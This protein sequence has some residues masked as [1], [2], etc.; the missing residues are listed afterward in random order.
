MVTYV[1]QRLLQS[2]FVLVLVSLITFL[3]LQL[4][5]DPLSLLIE[6]QAPREAIEELRRELGL[7][8][9]YHIQFIRFLERAARGDL[10]DSLRYGSPTLPIALG[11]LP[12]TIELS[13]AAMAMALVVGIP[14][15]IISAVNRNSRR[16]YA[17]RFA[18]FIAQAVPFFWLA[19]M[20]ILIVSVKLEWLPTS[21]RGDWRHLI[22]PAFTLALLPMARITRLLRSSLL[23]V[24]RED[25]I[26]VA[27]AKGLRPR[28]VVMGHAVRNALLPVV[29]D[30]AILFGSLLS[31]AIIIE[32]IFAWPGIGR[33]VIDSIAS[34]DYPM[35]QTLVMLNAAIFIALNLLADVSYVLIDP[36]V[37]RS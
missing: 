34:R 26:T 11:R 27:R 24:L 2:L 30:I 13:L 14:A 35:V 25:Y 36:R 5:G 22:L 18:A 10:G 31:G 16:D 20:L 17:I 37:R 8:Q 33:L 32:T 7:D 28:S 15:G 19:I 23:S 21:G 3:I 6:P 29:T 4:S 9:P 12:A 1:L